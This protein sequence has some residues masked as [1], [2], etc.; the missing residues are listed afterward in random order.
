MPVFAAKIGSADM[1]GAGYRLPIRFNRTSLAGLGN[2]VAPACLGL[3]L[4]VSSLYSSKYAI[5]ILVLPLLFARNRKLDDFHAG[6]ILTALLAAFCATLVLTTSMKADWSGMY[7]TL[8][9][10]MYAAL[11]FFHC[12]HFKDSIGYA[13]RFMLLA[14]FAVSLRVLIIGSAGESDPQEI[15][16]RI[17]SPILVVP[18]D[19]AAFLVMGPIL[20]YAVKEFHSA[21]G[22]T[23]TVCI[24]IT[25]LLASIVLESRLCLL[26]LLIWLMLDMPIARYWRRIVLCL[27]IVLAL[28]AAL[29]G[30]ETNLLAK[31][32]QIPTS[33]IPVWDAALYQI[34]TS[35]LIG[36][37]IDSFRQFYATHL[38]TANYSD[39]IVVDSRQMPWAH[40]LLLDVSIAFGIPAAILLA[41]L[42]SYVALSAWRP[43]GEMEKAMLVSILM[44]VAAALF[45]FTHLRIYPLAMIAIYAGYAARIPGK[46]ISGGVR[47]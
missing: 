5:L 1:E 18:N 8:I 44:F 47:V 46:A 16:N 22:K 6:R 45:E 2:S 24:W 33:R 15:V 21:I 7:P 17:H 31:I 9:M 14:F 43:R 19:Y 4:C 13:A 39:F 20:G 23:L 3:F 11:I 36:S 29:I 12:A 38:L 32:N 42:L 41:A 26:L 30:M 27:G 35:P 34:A 10:V 37:G 28:A 25:A 40:N